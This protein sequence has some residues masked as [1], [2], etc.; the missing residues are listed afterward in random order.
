MASAEPYAAPSLDDSA[1]PRPS[2]FIALLLS[3]LAP[4][5]GQYHAG[6]P[7][8]AVSWLV[9][10]AGLFVVFGAVARGGSFWAVA[11]LAPMFVVV[12]VAAAVDAYRVAKKPDAARPA[13]GAVLAV[14]VVFVV[15]DR[16]AAFL[17]RRYLVEAYNV[18]SGA[19]IPTLL[20]GDHLFADKAPGEPARGDVVLFE[21]PEDR[22]K[23]FLSRV[24]GMPGETLALE[25]G[26][27]VVDGKPVP[28]CE[29]G[30]LNRQVV[31]VEWLDGRAHLVVHDEGA[32]TTGGPWTVPAG[33]SFVM[34]D[35]RDNAHD[36]R[37]WFGGQGGGVPRDHV[38]GRALFLWWSIDARG[39]IASDR[40][41]VDVHG[42][43]LP[44]SMASLAA[45]L[46]KCLAK[47]P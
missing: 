8:R 19:M 39:G 23:V 29:V 44:D 4:G 20:V 43:T 28:R 22:A 16:G 11:G 30:R 31:W 24:V 34:G 26:R 3:L 5:A 42:V 37:S 40:I 46:A 9:G 6:S 38:I 35:N 36:S 41:G 2:A 47:G 10:V 32:E 7:A 12:R 33:Q 21:F 18:P 45:A 17:T 13:I 25:A 1:R 15:A 27:L 14:A